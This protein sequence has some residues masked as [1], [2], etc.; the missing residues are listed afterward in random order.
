[1]QLFFS[2]QDENTSPIFIAVITFVLLVAVFILVF[3]SVFEF[4]EMFWVEHISPR[5][6]YK[7][8]YL[9][10]QKLTKDQ[11][12]ILKTEFSFYQNLKKRE[13]LY[14]EHRVAKFIK[15]H[16]FKGRSGVYIDNQKKVLISSTVVM[17]TFGYRNYMIKSLDKFLIYP[18]VFYSKINKAR[19]K[20][21][22]NA[23]YKAIIFSWEDFMQGYDIS[24]DNFN[25]GIHEVVHAM[26]FD[27]LK[28]NNH[29]TSASIFIN[30][31]HKL[32]NF[33]KNDKVYKDN[34]VTSKYLRN[35]A[36]TNN[37][38]FIAVLI[39]S[40]FETPLELKAQF[41]EIYSYVKKMLNF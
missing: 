13:K 32:L 31:Y 19:H 21:E 18:G 12:Y 38:E 27:Y 33:L 30:Q 8:L 4:V 41:P 3:K 37:F 6:F 39:E 5:P 9:R 36:F 35:Y 29:S 25:L 14:F 11:L 40:F 7:H 15:L 10:K 17:L 22:F 26:H 1:M 20:G 24:N 34:L 23:A 28:P 16:K 2:I